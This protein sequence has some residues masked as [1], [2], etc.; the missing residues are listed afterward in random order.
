[1][2]PRS[3]DLTRSQYAIHAGDRVFERAI[4]KSSDFVR[5]SR[6]P[7]A[8]AKRVPGMLEQEGMLSMNEEGGGQRTAVLAYP[9]LLNIAEGHD[10]F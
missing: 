1:M 5:A 10:A 8:T 3:V 9:A 7:E 2:K 6:I 4:F